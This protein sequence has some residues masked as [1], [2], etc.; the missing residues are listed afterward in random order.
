[1]PMKS[2]RS[3]STA[4][5]TFGL[6]LDRRIAEM[7]RLLVEMRPDSTADAL[8]ALRKAFPD[9][10]LNARIEAIRATRH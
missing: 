9:T 6:P 8:Q 2:H 4:E 1:M 3:D 7:R 10:P 5:P